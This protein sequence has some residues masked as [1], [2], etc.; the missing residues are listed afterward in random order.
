MPQG[1]DAGVQSYS[2]KINCWCLPLPEL[3]STFLEVGGV[4]KKHGE[5]S[6]QEDQGEDE[7]EGWSGS[8][9]RKQLTLLISVDTEANILQPVRVHS[10][11]TLQTDLWV[12][13]LGQRTFNG[14]L[15]HSII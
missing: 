4:D 10:Q 9:I 1:K 3:Y 2:E 13:I 15:Q 5:F 11:G 8:R 12:A 14:R 7:G 6:Q